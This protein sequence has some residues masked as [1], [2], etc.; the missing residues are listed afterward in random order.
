MRKRMTSLLL[1]LAL[2]LTLPP[3]AAFAVEDGE[4][5]DALAVEAQEGREEGQS[6]P[7]PQPKQEEGQSDPEPET[8][9]DGAVAAVQ[10]LIDALPAVDELDG[11]DDDD[12]M[13]VYEAFQTAC[14]AYYE[15]LTEEQQA[16]L[17]NTEKLRRCPTVQPPAALAE[18]RYI[19]P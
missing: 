8:E 11:M 14:D 10:A 7:E 12:A 18:S 5:P 17:K 15:T 6:D 9:P 3:T 19:S 4:G 2:C 1:V 16:Q 13:A